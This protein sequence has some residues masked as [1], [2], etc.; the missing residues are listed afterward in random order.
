MIVSHLMH[1]RTIAGLGGILLVAIMVAVMLAGSAGAHHRDGHEK[2]G[3]NDTGGG[4]TATF[5][6][7][8]SGDLGGNVTAATGNFNG[9]ESGV[10]NNPPEGEILALSVTGFLVRNGG[11]EW[12][13]CF[14]D[15][16]FADAI[17]AVS[18]DKNDPGFGSA[19]FWFTAKD[20]DGITDIW[21]N[22]WATHVA[23]D[24]PDGAVW[25]YWL[26][27]VGQ[28]VI[29]ATKAGEPWNL[30]HANGPGRKVACT[31]DG[32]TG[33]GATGGGLNDKLHFVI[34]IERIS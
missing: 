16:P 22:L 30:K 10:Q 21:Y 9:K 24:P 8:V 7:T 20:K 3:G 25:P 14:G 19:A 26:P 2:G 11:T 23:I 15:G 29:V 13:K 1:L 12:N 18:A 17:V 4:D 27:D 28:T 32:T 33:E 31:G 34:T 5:V 6:I